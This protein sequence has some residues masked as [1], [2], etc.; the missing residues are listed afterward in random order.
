MA[1]QEPS[2]VV[3]EATSTMK[4]AAK[5]AASNMSLQQKMRNWILLDNQ[6]TDHI[7]CNKEL[8]SDIKLGGDTLELLSNGGSLTTSMT[9]QFENFKERV[10]YHE[11]DV[12]NILSFA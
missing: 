10:W 7:F 1:R 11:E 2:K 8:L 12:T 4:K 5:L 3:Q 9:G 6:S